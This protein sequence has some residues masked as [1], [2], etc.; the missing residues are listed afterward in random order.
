M[1]KRN[2]IISV[3]WEVTQTRKT[4]T[5]VMKFCQLQSRSAPEGTWVQQGRLEIPSQAQ[6]E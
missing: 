2:T 6:P 4:P 5:F 3:L 1:N